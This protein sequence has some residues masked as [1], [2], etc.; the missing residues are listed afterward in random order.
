MLLNYNMGLVE[1]PDMKA[2]DPPKPG[3][4]PRKKT[5]LSSDSALC[6]VGKGTVDKRKRTQ[7][8]ITDKNTDR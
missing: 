1:G 8:T 3:K 5:F 2:V 4:E 6:V 7:I